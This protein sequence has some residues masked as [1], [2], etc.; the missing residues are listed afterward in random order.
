ME[1]KIPL[2]SVIGASALLIKLPLEIARR[3]HDFENEN[4]Q[5]V[6]NGDLKLKE[7][8]QLVNSRSVVLLISFFRCWKGAKFSFLASL[9]HFQCRVSGRIARAFPV[10]SHFLD[11]FVFERNSYFGWSTG[12]FHLRHR[13][14]STHPRWRPR[15]PIGEL[16]HSFINHIIHY[17]QRIWTPFSGVKKCS[18]LWLMNKLVRRSRK[19]GEMVM[20]KVR[21]EK[22]M[23][24]RESPFWSAIRYAELIIFLH[25]RLSV[26][27]AERCSIYLDASTVRVTE[28]HQSCTHARST[29]MSSKLPFLFT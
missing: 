22:K 28:S 14:P 10:F 3:H 25:G 27:T 5:R 29:Q 24:A 4:K 9:L 21:E 8:L 1:R 18:F 23:R 16:N 2:M 6:W 17:V 12:F 13:T 20:T 7:T 19:K 26:F 15:R 11:N